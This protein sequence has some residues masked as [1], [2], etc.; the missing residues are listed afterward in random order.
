MSCVSTCIFRYPRSLCTSLLS[1]TSHVSS[2]LASQPDLRLC[3]VWACGPLFITCMYDPSP[4]T[5]LILPLEH[6]ML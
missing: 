5:S 1:S 3:I 2:S 4:V 6:G